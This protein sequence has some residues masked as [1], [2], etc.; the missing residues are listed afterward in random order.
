MCWVEEGSALAPRAVIVL[1]VCRGV[2]QCLAVVGKAVAD[3]TGRHKK[4][5]WDAQNTAFVIGFGSNTLRAPQACSHPTRCLSLHKH[6]AGH[7][8]VHGLP[9]HPPCRHARQRHDQHRCQ[10]CAELLPVRLLLH[11][12]RVGITLCK[13]TDRCAGK[14]GSTTC[15]AAT[16]ET[17]RRARMRT[18]LHAPSKDTPGPISAHS[19]RP[20]PRLS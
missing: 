16:T 13:P 12:D 15:T 10:V 6:H 19:M 17:T 9:A 2:R 5:E 20:G 7:R 4:Q 11:D 8:H 1:R 18:R 3:N 14:Q